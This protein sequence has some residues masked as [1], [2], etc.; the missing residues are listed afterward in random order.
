[1]KRLLLAT[2]AVFMAAS[3]FSAF[4]PDY[5]DYTFYV[6][7]D[8]QKDKTYLEEAL[9]EAQDPSEKSQI[10]WRLSRVELTLGD[11]LPED[12]KDAR[13]AAYEKAEE[14]AIESIELEPNADAYHWKSSALG[15]WGQTKG[16]LD[17]LGKAPGMLDDVLMVIDHFGY[18]YTDSWYVLGVLYN[19]LPGWPLSFGDKN[20]AISYMRRSLDTRIAER[21]I[22]LTLFQEL[23]DQLYD[24]N[25]N[26][27]KR[28]KEFAKMHDSYEENTVMSEKM[29]YY[30]GAEAGKNKPFY[31]TVALN[32]IS[33]RQEAVMLLRYAE[34]LYKA[35]K[36]P[37]PSET[38]KY[39]EILARLAEIT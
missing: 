19:Q 11:Q 20:Y 10:L 3:L 9:A 27:K 30:E 18:D 12:D 31:S 34:A 8:F 13:F 14:L 5:S 15:R 1:M 26:A 37:L 36:N 6:E 28:T 16:P 23:S 25:W 2:L 21:G 29:K 7:E 35:K 24:R 32:D 39:K 4:N 38:E 22:Y 17:S 33:D